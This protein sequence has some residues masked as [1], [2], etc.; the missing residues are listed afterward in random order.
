MFEANEEASVYVFRKPCD[1]RCG[2]DRLSE[3]VKAQTQ[4]NPLKG[5]YFVFLSRSKDRVKI[6]MWE[7]DGFWLFYKRL[8]AGTFKVS[9]CE[10]YEVITEVDLKALLQGMELERIK[11]RKSTESGCF[12][13]S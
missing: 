13:G 3:Y 10:G 5:D 12:S 2:F 1:M 7:R 11:L 8:E 9:F 6:L 4:V